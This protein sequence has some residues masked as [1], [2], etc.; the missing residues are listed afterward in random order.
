MQLSARL[1]LVTVGPKV[2]SFEV[3][4]KK[5]SKGPTIAVYNP[6]CGGRPASTEYANPC[7]ITMAPTVTPA[8]ISPINHFLLYFGS[9]EIIGKFS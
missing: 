6:Y 1:S 3:P 4:I 9:H 2:M 8:I 7:G 5:Y